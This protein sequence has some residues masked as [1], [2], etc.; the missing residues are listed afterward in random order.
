M[1][2]YNLEAAPTA[3][4]KEI[5][6]QKAPKAKLIAVGIDAHLRG[7]QAS[8][9]VD[10]AAVGPVQNL[11]SE[12]EVLLYAEKQLDTHIGGRGSARARANT[13]PDLRGRHAPRLGTEPRPVA[14]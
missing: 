6:N 14:P 13:R 7:Y 2:T 4:T 11:R 3:L 8:R 10:N 5:K 1:K 12:T 9:E